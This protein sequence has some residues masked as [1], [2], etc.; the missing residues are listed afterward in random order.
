MKIK[1]IAS[2]IDG[3]LINDQGM[4]TPMTRYV[5]KEASHMGILIAIASGRTKG[6]MAGILSQM[7][8]L[9]YLIQSNGASILDIKNNRVIY[10]RF[11]SWERIPD[12]FEILSHYGVG[13]HCFINSNGYMDKE[14]LEKY[15]RFCKKHPIPDAAFLTFTCIE[16]LIDKLSDKRPDIEKI[17]VVTED[18]E[19]RRKLMKELGEIPELEI[20]SATW[21]NIEINSRAATKGKALTALSEK[22]CIDLD[23]I[24]VFGDNYNDLSMLKAVNLGIAMENA[25]DDVKKQAHFT[26]CSNNEDGIAR[27]AASKL[28][29]DISHFIK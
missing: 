4:I 15:R 24:M 14:T 13:F 28:N 22:L 17:A 27:F 25:P 18:K 29:I 20:S 6:A 2:D 16:H 23:E 7:P 26:T 8:A 3:T 9:D 1:L 10:S 11:L 19:L 21:Y 5:I 12:I